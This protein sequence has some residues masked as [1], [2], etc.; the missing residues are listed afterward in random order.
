LQHSTARLSEL[1]R[2]VHNEGPQHVIVHGRDE[3]VVIAADEYQRLSGDV[4]GAGLVAAVQASSYREIEIE[5]VRSPLPV[6]DLVLR[7]TGF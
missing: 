6:R 7:P 2:K 5:P 4:I 3:V 1:V